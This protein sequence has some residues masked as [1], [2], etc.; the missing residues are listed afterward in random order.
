[1]SDEL[2]IPLSITF[3]KSYQ[4]SALPSSWL[5]SLVYPIYK[6]SGPRASADNYRP[7]SQTSLVCKTMETIINDCMLERL[8]SQSLII[9]YQ[10]GFLPKQSTTSALVLTYLNWISSYAESN[11]HS[12]CIYFDLSKAFDSVCHRKLIHKISYYSLHPLC[13]NWIKAFLSGRTQRMKI[14]ST[15]SLPTVC[16]SGV[17]QGSVLSSILFLLYMNDL[18]QVIKNSKICLFADHVKLYTSVNSL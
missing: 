7:V 12:Y 10:Y 8:M 16:I 15:T 6:S 14:K 1:M 13:L 3:T 5:T 17:P 4:L 2:A 18:P 9:P 11:K